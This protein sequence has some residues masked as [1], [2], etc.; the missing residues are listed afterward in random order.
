MTPADKASEKKKENAEVEDDLRH[1][2][3]EEDI[4]LEDRKPGLQETE[5]DT[6]I[7]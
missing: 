5:D 2:W 1:E 4:E 7:L 6:S 3:V